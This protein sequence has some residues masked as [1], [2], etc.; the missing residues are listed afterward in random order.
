MYQ[1]SDYKMDCKEIHENSKR[2][3]TGDCRQ[4]ETS[5]LGLTKGQGVH[6]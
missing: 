4:Q 3:I 2:K 1:I 6:G 5:A